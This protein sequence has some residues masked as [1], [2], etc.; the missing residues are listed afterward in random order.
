[1]LF[2]FLTCIVKENFSLKQGKLIYC[3]F[4]FTLIFQLT[5]HI[6]LLL[7]VKQS[8]EQAVVHNIHNKFI[9]PQNW[10]ISI[11]YDWISLPSL[12]DSFS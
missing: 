12:S 8:A 10:N 3:N 5:H 11:Q 2:T 9:F 7:N 4:H 6:L 1:M